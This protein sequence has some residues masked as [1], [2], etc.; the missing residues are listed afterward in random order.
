MEDIAQ[1][2]R[3]A[4]IDHRRGPAIVVAGPGSGKTTIL[5]ERIASICKE[6]GCDPTRVVAVTFTNHAA[7]QMKEKVAKHFGGN[8]PPDIRIGTLHAFA[9][10]LLHRYSDRLTLPLRFRVVGKLQEAILI[11]DAQLE[12]KKQRLGLGHYR[13]QYLRRFKAGRALLPSLDSVAEIPIKKGYATQEQFDE[14]YQNLL[15]YYHS[16][17]WYDIVILAV[18]VLQSHAEDVLREITGGIEHLLVDEYQDLNR[19]DHELVRLLSTKSKSLMVFGDDDQ[20]IYQTGRYANPGGV[21]RFTEIYPEAK[22]YPLSICWRCCSSVLDA[23]WK[24]IDQDEKRMPERMPKK[25]SLP[26]PDRG[27]GLFEIKPFKSEKAEARAILSE[28]RNELNGADRPTDILILFH[29]RDIGHN[30]VEVFKSEGLEFQD[31]LGQSQALSQWVV[32]LYEMLR[33]V[34]DESDNLAAR[35]LLEKFFKMNSAWIA[36]ARRDS[37]TSN[38]PLWRSAI[39]SAD[40]TQTIK[41]WEGKLQRWRQMGDIIDVL[42]G[43]I[44]DMAIGQDPG[45][46]KIQGWC[47]G[48]KDLSIKGMVERLERGFDF[49]EPSEEEPKDGCVTKVMT[50]H[51]AKGIDADVVFV[52]AL[53]NELL[54]NEWYEPEQRRLLYVSMTRAKRRLLLSWA[55]SR[56][57]RATY[58]N[59]SRKAVGRQRSRF[60]DD[61]EHANMVRSHRI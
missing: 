22:V 32:S 38:E 7:N 13:N 2:E 15:A 34:N 47:Q 39:R 50:M 45:V 4:I 31:L 9:K 54:P 27:S 26:C 14:C 40:A 21:K 12:L 18:K 28:L 10:G 56:T 30:Y 58:R 6:D 43:V 33:L 46:T 5:A 44:R 16:L 42:G 23:A 41:A 25:R 61:I 59:P 48:K 57:G 20:S 36:L 51:G 52:P 3:K 11:L 29:S 55:W 53:E 8:S 1:Y 24:L 60:L 17:D 49:D 19:A 35:Y 37:R